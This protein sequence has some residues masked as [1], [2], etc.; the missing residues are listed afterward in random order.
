M[1]DKEIAEAKKLLSLITDPRIATF[2]DLRKLTQSA[3]YRKAVVMAADHAAK[4]GDFSF[5]NNVLALIDGTHHAAELI[6]SLRPKLT[7]VLTPTKPRKLKKA[8]PEL[9]AQVAAKAANTPV[10]PQKTTTRPVQKKKTVRFGKGGDLMD[11][12]LRLPGSFGSGKRR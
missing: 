6:E 11:S 7:F 12:H 10:V 2:L 4:H 5:L 1:E 3:Q 8:T 9:V